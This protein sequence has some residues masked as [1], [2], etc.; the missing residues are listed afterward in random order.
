MAIVTA[1][2]NASIWQVLVAVGDT[3]RADDEIMILESMKMEIPVTA[4]VDGVVTSIEAEP[5]AAVDVGSV[6]ARIE[7]P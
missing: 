7:T 5:G 6:L 4:P 2:I 3:V 1:E